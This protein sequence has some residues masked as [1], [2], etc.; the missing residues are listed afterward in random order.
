VRSAQGAAAAALVLSVAETQP[1]AVTRLRVALPGLPSALAGLKVAFASDFHYGRL[2]TQ[3]ATRA[4][5]DRIN[6]L[7]PDVTLLG[8]DYISGDARFFKVGIGELSRLSA[9][10]GVYAVPG[11]HDHYA[12][13][14]VYQE[15][16]KGTPIADITNSGVAIGADKGLWIAGLD[17]AWTGAPDAGLATAFAPPGAPRIV[18]THNPTLADDLPL[19]YGDL[20]LAGHTHGWQVYIPLLSAMIVPAPLRKYRAGFYQTRAGRMYVTRGIGT[21]GRPVRLWCSP[22]IALFELWPKGE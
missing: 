15:S 7:H 20:I 12:S 22:E 6:S 19:N 14:R 3:A 4:A 13:L 17:D 21:I 18:L 5:V 2:G 1:L 9:R 10:L 16:L 11:N 8:G